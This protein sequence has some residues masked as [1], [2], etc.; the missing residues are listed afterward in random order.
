MQ[1]EPDG[2][3]Q[4]FSAGVVPFEGGFAAQLSDLSLECVRDMLSDNTVPTNF[5][6]AVAA[7][8]ELSAAQDACSELCLSVF[9][10]DVQFVP[11]CG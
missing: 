7:L 5:D 4:V 1:V 2:A 11:G 9:E 3:A 10:G 6:E 8:A